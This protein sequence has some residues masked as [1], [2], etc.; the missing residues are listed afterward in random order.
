VLAH[1]NI[2]TLS[3]ELTEVAGMFFTAVIFVETFWA[4]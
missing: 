4:L 2:V 1:T 3:A